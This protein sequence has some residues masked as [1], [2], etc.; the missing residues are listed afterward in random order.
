MASYFTCIIVFLVCCSQTAS[1]RIYVHAIVCEASSMILARPDGKY[2]D[3]TGQ[4][5]AAFE[6]DTYARLY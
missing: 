4:Y 5:M 1:D 2:L 3:V 6:E